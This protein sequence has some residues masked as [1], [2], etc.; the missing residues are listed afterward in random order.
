VREALARRMA[1]AT[2]LPFESAHI[3]MTVGAG[4]A[5]NVIL[6]AMLD[7]GDEV[8]AL[9]PYFVEYGAYAQN[10][11]GR[12]VVVETRAD[13]Q[14][15]VAAIRAAI[16][17][18]TRVVLVNSPNNPTGAVYPA[19]FYQ[20]LEAMLATLDHVV[21]VVS[22][23]PYKALVYD[24]VRPPEVQQYVTSAIVATSWSKTLAVPGERIGMLA[25]SP[26]MPDAAQIVDACTLTNRVLGFVNAPALWQR[27][28]AEAAE[29][30]IDVGPY[31][32]KRDI[33]Y[34][35][36]RDI[37]YA[38]T[39]PLGAFYLFPETPL[40][41][42]VAF[43]QSLVD[44]GILAVPGVGFGRAGHMRLSLTVA[45]ETV[46]RSLPGFERAFRKARG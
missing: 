45:R 23:E 40:A 17:P 19:S 25:V 34:G 33:L 4:G 16:T 43:V 11:G 38:C 14:P 37:G 26:R 8:I 41:D 5:L 46:E 36:L 3:L 35:G 27:V 18:R 21:T 22:D 20:E 10:H 12:L 28:V 44:E 29:H 7:P 2:N 32:A 24:G 9:A 39:K 15:D 6:K 42:D 31:Q 13:F 30:T 1:A